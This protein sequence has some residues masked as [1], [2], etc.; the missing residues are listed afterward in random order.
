MGMSHAQ[1]GE[2]RNAEECF[3]ASIEELKICGYPN[4]SLANIFENLS[5]LLVEEGNYH[6]ALDN[7]EEAIRL[8]ESVQTNV[9]AS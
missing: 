9:Y 3:K 5:K 1:L 6:R 2:S 4:E 7:I 8:Q